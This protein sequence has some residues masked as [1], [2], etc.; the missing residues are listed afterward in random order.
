LHEWL[1]TII[2]QYG[3]IITAERALEIIFE[4][5]EASVEGASSNL[6]D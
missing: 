3:K 4:E 5:K 2:N 6:E 1:F